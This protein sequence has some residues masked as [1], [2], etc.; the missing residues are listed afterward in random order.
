[1]ADLRQRLRAGDRARRARRRAAM[2]DRLGPVQSGRPRRLRRGRLRRPR[3]RRGPLER[4]DRARR[5]PRQPNAPGLG[6]ARRRAHRHPRRWAGAREPLGRPRPRARARDH[7][8]ARAA[9]AGG[10]A[11][12]ARPVRPRVRGGRRGPAARARR[13]TVRAGGL[14]PVVSSRG[15][16]A[17]GTRRARPRARRGAA[18][19]RPD[20]AAR[21]SSESSSGGRSGCSSS[22]WA[23]PPRRSITCSY[24]SRPSVPSPT[25][26]SCSGSRT[27][28]RPRSAPTASAM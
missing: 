19:T 9:G 7:A 5:A 18:G 24:R 16:R 6:R 21:P 28:S 22:G 13:R 15:R 10:P 20:R 14:E 23:D 4:G 2:C 8:A 12:R 17:A 25:R 26:W 11:D 1:M 3:S 27:R